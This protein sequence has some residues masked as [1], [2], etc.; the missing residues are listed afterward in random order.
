MNVQ[1]QVFIRR[2]DKSSMEHIPRA[3]P[4]SCMLPESCLYVL[5][6]DMFVLPVAISTC[7]WDTQS[8]LLALHVVAVILKPL[9]VFY[10]LSICDTFD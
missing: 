10:L 8:L 5:S 6:M 4:R 1:A 7:T 3:Q 9:C 2:K